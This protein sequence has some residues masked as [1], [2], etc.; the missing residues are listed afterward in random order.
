MNMENEWLINILQQWELYER[1]LQVWGLQ[2]FLHLSFYG[3]R[4]GRFEEGKKFDGSIN[5]AFS[6]FLSDAF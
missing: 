3:V 2:G 1:D 5:T 4:F 6:S